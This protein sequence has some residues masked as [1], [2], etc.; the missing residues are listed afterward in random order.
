MKKFRFGLFPGMTRDTVDN[1]LTDIECEF[2]FNECEPSEVV[3]TVAGGGDVQHD[4]YIALKN[5]AEYMGDVPEAVPENSGLSVDYYQCPIEFPTTPGRAPYT[6]ECNDIIEALGMMPSEANIF[7]E[8]WRNA[9]ART[10][11]KLKEGNTP[12][13]AYQKVYFFAKR[14]LELLTRERIE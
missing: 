12:L 10:L 9:A 2:Q 4:V 14:Q 13:R 6:A 11:G 1:A 8:T 3:V 5:I 7:K